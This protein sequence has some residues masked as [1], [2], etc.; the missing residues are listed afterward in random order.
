MKKNMST[1]DRATRIVL[2]VL[3]IIL[4]ASGT[5]T[6]ALGI[7]L[8]ALVGIVIVSSLIGF[9]PLYALLGMHSL[10]IHHR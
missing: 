8:F 1:P 2:A 5:V 10:K 9:C 4:Y 6:G 7:I 3:I